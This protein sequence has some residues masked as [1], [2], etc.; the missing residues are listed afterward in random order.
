MAHIIWGPTGV[1]NGRDR[2]F[3]NWTDFLCP[4]GPGPG[5]K[6]AGERDRDKF[7]RDCPTGQSGPGQKTA[8]L[9]VLSLAHP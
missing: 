1:K 4:V 9:P 5:Q 3:L 6:S 7:W 8:G 2:L